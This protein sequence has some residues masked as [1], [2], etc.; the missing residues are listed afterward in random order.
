MS[1]K[2]SLDIPKD[3]S[4]IE[5]ALADLDS[6]L[7]SWTAT[8]CE[9]QLLQEQTSEPQEQ[10]I[11]SPDQQTESDV[12]IDESTPPTPAT[13]EDLSNDDLAVSE[14]EVEQEAVSSSIDTEEQKEES[15]ESAPD[16]DDDEEILDSLDEDTAKR[17]RVLRRI[18]NGKKSV[19]ELLQ[20]Y[21]VAQRENKVEEKPKKSWFRMGR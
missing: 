10:L 1:D 19:R 20:E 15:L 18:T 2:K 11:E 6:K 17:I 7:A 14:S 8:V 12:P 16:Q 4:S 3:N 5:Q 21:Q 9:S 13:T